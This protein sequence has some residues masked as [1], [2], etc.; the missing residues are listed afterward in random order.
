[1]SAGTTYSPRYASAFRVAIANEM[2]RG[3]NQ[4]PSTGKPA[5]G[6][7]VGIQAAESRRHPPPIEIVGIVQRRDSTPACATVFDLQPQLFFPILE[8][9][10][11]R[12]CDSSSSGH[13]PTLR[14]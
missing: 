4:Y 10:D 6:R 14:P 7:H 8:W 1:M 12:E 2:C 5:L 13:T 3:I 11:P 9:G